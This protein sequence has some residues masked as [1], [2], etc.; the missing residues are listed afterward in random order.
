MPTSRT[1][2][3][4]SISAPFRYGTADMSRPPSGILY[5]GGSLK[6]NGYP[7]KI[8]HIRRDEIPD[9]VDAICRD[10][11]ALFVGFSMMTGDQVSS[12]ALMSSMLKERRPAT[13]IVWG[14][15]HPSLMPGESLELG[16]ADYVVIGE[17][18]AAAVDLAG[19]LSSGSPGRPDH[20]EG[21]AFR[22]GDGIVITPPRPFAG[23]IDRYRQD[24]SLVDPARYVRVEG[25]ERTF[26]FITSRGCPHSCGFCYNAKFNMRRW[27]AHSIG[28][29]ERELARIKEQTGITSVI[30]DDDNFFTN[31]TRGLDIL[32]KLRDRGIVCRWMNLRVDYISGE[33]VEELIERGVE[34]IFMGWE[35]GNPETLKRITKGFS[36]DLILEKT[37][38]LSK[39]PGLVVDASAIIGFPWETE[40]DIGRTISLMLKMFR[41][42]PFRMNFNLGLYVPFPG[43][44]VTAEAESRGF[45]FPKRSE[46]WSKFDILAGTME[47]PWMSADRVR[48]YARA[49]RYA[50]LLF[51]SR[52]SSP[53]MKAVQYI[54]CALAYARLTAG[55]FAFPFELW[56]S[57]WYKKRRLTKSLTGPSPGRSAPSEMTA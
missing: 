19:F 25:P 12:S 1:V 42:N 33:L 41:L 18:E 9:T 5:V 54:L 13:R 28:F 32:R 52:K 31:R 49:D 16:C 45:M 27:R 10:D 17:G 24:F 3:L 7:V 21:I 29:V 51:V 4:I 6:K 20:I 34:T 35:S 23:D 37:S 47:L 43:S 2:H 36:V 38:I 44:P 56:L 26:C 30:F 55:V 46:G 8:H 11:D 48:H 40:A 53:W 22:S 14:G 15:I 57:D 50:K 39:F